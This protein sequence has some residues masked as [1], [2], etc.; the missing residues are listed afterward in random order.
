MTVAIDYRCRGQPANS[1][2]KDSEA[3]QAWRPIPSAPSGRVRQGRAVAQRCRE[4]GPL[5][6]PVPPASR[7]L[8]PSP[9]RAAGHASA[10]G[11][12]HNQS[13]S[14][15][16]RPASSRRGKRP[17]RRA[18]PPP[19]RQGHSA[20]SAPMPLTM[21]ERIIL[22]A[23]ASPTIGPSAR[24]SAA[25]STR[26]RAN[27]MLPIA[28]MPVSDSPSLRPGP[29]RSRRR[30]AARRGRGGGLHRS[31]PRRGPDARQGRPWTWSNSRTARCSAG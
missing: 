10:F 3:V 2:A 17:R 31:A 23:L 18:P 6:C 22:T 28:T 26:A 29:P 13:G 7:P 21:T 27:G 20:E 30:R 11:R 25:G 1:A 12:D 24:T 8:L 16:L 15:S 9:P 14:P 5:R 19:R 4:R